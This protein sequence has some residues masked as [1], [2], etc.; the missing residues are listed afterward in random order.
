MPDIY[1]FA[2]RKKWTLPSGRSVQKSGNYSDT[3]WN[4]KLTIS[5]IIS[6]NPFSSLFTFSAMA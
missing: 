4:R 6:H 5:S 2:G 3:D 1:H